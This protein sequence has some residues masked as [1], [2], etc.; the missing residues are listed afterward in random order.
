MT[1]ANKNAATGSDADEL[2]DV[3]TVARMC[4]VSVW[5]VYKMAGGGRMPKP[6]KVGRLL[7]WKKR[8]IQRWINA[9]CPSCKGRKKHG[10]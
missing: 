7:R 10:S 8:A 5:L 3:K 9:G 2:I 1:D 6:I 4:R